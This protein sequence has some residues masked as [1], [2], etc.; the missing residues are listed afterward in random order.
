MKAKERQLRQKLKNEIKMS[1]YNYI[2]ETIMS[3]VTDYEDL[4]PA[5]KLQLSIIIRQSNHVSG[6]LVS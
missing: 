6:N 2:I 5:L 1:V 3:T 4:S